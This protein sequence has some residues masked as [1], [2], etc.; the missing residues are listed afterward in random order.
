[1][2]RKSYADGGLLVNLVTTSDAPLDTEGFVALVRGLW[3]DRVQGILHTLND[4]V[5]ERVEARTDVGLALF[6]KVLSLATKD[7]VFENCRWRIEG[8]E[9]EKTARAVVNEELDVPNCFTLETSFFAHSAP[10]YV[11]AAPSSS[12]ATY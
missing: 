10:E 9:H 12:G 11:S 6:P 7:F 5:G 3:G 1:M 4:D 2:V 8:K